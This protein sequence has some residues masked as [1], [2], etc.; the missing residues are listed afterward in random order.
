[1]NVTFGE[2]VTRYLNTISSKKATTTHMREKASAKRLVEQ[3]GTKTPFGSIS[4]ATV[5]GYRD[6]RMQRVSAYSVRQELTLLSHLFTKAKK[7]WGIPVGNPVAEIE[8]PVPPRGRTRF[9]TKNENFL[10]GQNSSGKE[11]GGVFNPL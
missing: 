3:I 2:A 6:D 1:M 7:E 5:A 8:R 4:A 10:L 9:L 11:N